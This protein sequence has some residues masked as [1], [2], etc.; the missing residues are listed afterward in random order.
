MSGH[1][2]YNIPLGASTMQLG[3]DPIIM[4]ILNL[5]PDSFSD[6]GT[7]KSA[8]DALSHARA[9]MEEGA[10]IV[11][12]GGESTR[13]EADEVSVQNELDRVIIAI[14][15]LAEYEPDMVVSIDTY[16]ALVADQAV[17]SGA[18]IINDVNGLQREPEIADVAALHE[19]PII[20]MHWDKQRDISKDIISEMKYFFGK[21]IE[22][23]ENAGVPH[24]MLVL[25][26]G[27]G[28]AKNLTENYEILRRLGELHSLGFPLLVG[29]SAK[30][31]I[32]NLLDLPVNERLS[33]TSATNIMAYNAGAHIF[34]V[35]NVKE[36][37]RA[38]HVARATLHC[39]HEE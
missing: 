19:V 32:G 11:D 23:A 8:N 15:T 22:I 5:T 36:N 37:L 28:F 12:V 20:A 31:M 18:K 33:G 29:T 9:M 1:V 35:H 21:S 30:S 17:Q 4:G 14:E 6:G 16:K 24:N 25:D 13:P 26:P 2:K 38:L 39:P 7:H 27:F 3:P 10:D 34:R